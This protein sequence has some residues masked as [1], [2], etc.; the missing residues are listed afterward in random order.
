MNLKVPIHG[1]FYEGLYNLK[2]SQ[3]R[4]ASPLA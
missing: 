2:D 1:A 3:E 4:S